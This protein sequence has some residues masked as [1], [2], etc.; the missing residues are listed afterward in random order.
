[1]R[2]ASN[3]W[4]VILAGGEGSRLREL[5]TTA[6]G[7]TIPKQFCSLRRNACLIEDALERARA[8]ALP[9]HICSVVAAQHR[10]WWT[11]PLKPLPEQ[12]I[13]IQPANRGTA[14]GILFALLKVE[15]RNE[16]AIVVLLP[17]DHYVSDEST[18]ARSLRV[19]ANLASDNRRII[20]LLGAEP[21]SPDVELGY[22]VPTEQRRDSPAGVRRFVEKPSSARA[23][24]LLAEG[25][26][27]N[28]FI[29][30]GS[31]RSLLNLFDE[32]SAPALSA[33]RE[34]IA[35]THD[36]RPGALEAFYA[37]LEPVDF[38]RA[39]LQRRE[40]LLQVLRMPSCG[41]T[42]L[43]TPQRLESVIQTLRGDISLMRQPQ[44]EAK[45][46]YLDL[47]LPRRGCALTP[48]YGEH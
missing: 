13:F 46:L 6:E 29:V 35:H 44:L 41:W 25:A 9:Q 23:R 19:A 15:A 21:D 39:V 43:G 27:W 48:S 1:M 14:N 37:E 33:M 47:A 11:A 8:I 16:D 12:N 26:L 45:A 34:A 20:Y 4:A 5:T 7:Q 30:A 40:Q 22:I 10:R 31:V 38:S 36:S 28:T 3:T 17:A 2:S 32:K 18:M 42:D 24:Q